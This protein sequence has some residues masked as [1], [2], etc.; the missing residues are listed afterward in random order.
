MS[1]DE[2]SFRELTEP[3]MTMLYNYIKIKVYANADIEDILQ[4]TMLSVWQSL[5]GY[6]AQSTFK[7]W[8]FS[9][10]KRKIADF[11]RERQAKTAINAKFAE[12]S[13]L[14]HDNANIAD[15]AGSDIFS[16]IDEKLDLYAALSKMTEEN[17]ELIYLVFNAGL[18][19]EEIQKMTGM[20]TGT[21]K[22]RIHYIKKTLYSMLMLNGNGKGKGGNADE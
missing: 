21:I 12:L 16:Q 14:S 3:Y 8:I 1:G 13:D 22:S 7:T 2:Y 19:Y 9:I 5:A 17:R 18:T 10:A 6:S 20:K 4:N 11:Y 15:T